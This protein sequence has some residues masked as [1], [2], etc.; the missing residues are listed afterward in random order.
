LFLRHIVYRVASGDAELVRAV[1]RRINALDPVDWLGQRTD[2]LERA[3][4]RYK[5]LRRSLPAVPPR[6]ELLAALSP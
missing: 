6:S 3:L 1:A 5:E 4:V 2:L